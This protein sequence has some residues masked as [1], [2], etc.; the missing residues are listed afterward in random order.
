MLLCAR[1]DVGECLLLHIRLFKI[2]VDC[3]YMQ[4]LMI[5]VHLSLL[6]LRVLRIWY[7]IYCYMQ[8]GK[9]CLLVCVGICI[10][11]TDCC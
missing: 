9:I 1:Q 5:L 7:D 8:G 2:L 4:V 10:G 3:C 6:Y 11:F